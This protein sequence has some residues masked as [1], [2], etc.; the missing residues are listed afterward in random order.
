MNKK[1]K[2]LF[3]RAVEFGFDESEANFHVKFHEVSLRKLLDSKE[4]K[5]SNCWEPSPEALA[6][7]ESD[8]AK[9]KKT[10]IKL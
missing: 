1:Q 9:A 6:E 8:L 4:E 5:A 10:I 7:V 2:E 3:D